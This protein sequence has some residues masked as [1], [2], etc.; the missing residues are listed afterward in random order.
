MQTALASSK[1]GD[2]SAPG[3][4]NTP[5]P[6]SPRLMM[7]WEEVREASGAGV[8]IGAHTETHP[9]LSR[10]GREGQLAE[11]RGSI[12]A[13]VEQTGRRPALFSYPEGTAESRDAG[14]TSIL[15][16]LGIRFAMTTEAGAVGPSNLPLALNRIGVNPGDP[17]SVVALK[18]R[19]QDSGAA[20]ASAGG[21][22]KARLA[23]RQYGAWNAAK[24]GIKSLLRRA[25]VR[26]ETDFVLFRDLDGPIEAAKPVP[27]LSV[28]R[29]TREELRPAPFS[30]NS[31]PTKGP[32]GIE[33]P[34]SG[35]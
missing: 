21:A 4:S 25:G 3:G 30:A 2:P 28:K 19:S 11:I 5:F 16:S 23:L 33:V 12:E 14:T 1:R 18:T 17:G 10:L 15:R 7:N 26:V 27:G 24:R 22:R 13:I 20:P 8:V 6:S 31:R 35:L 34:L 9:I 32:R 29:L